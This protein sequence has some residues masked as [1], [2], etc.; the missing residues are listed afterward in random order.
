MIAQI[1]I[2]VFGMSAVFLVN[3]KRPNVR[4]WG[5]VC[6]VLAQPFWFYETATQGQWFIFATSLVYAA[7][8]VR[9]VWNFWVMEKQLYAAWGFFAKEQWWRKK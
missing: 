1:G 6:G 3:D 5:P 9:G 7:G 8:W 2:F 4:R